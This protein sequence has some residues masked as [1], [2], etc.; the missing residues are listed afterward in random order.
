MR[1]SKNTLR[2][3][4][5]LWSGRRWCLRALQAWSFRAKGLPAS[6]AQ[7]EPSPPCSWDWPLLDPAHKSGT[8]YWFPGISTPLIQDK[9]K[10]KSKLNI[11]KKFRW[12]WQVTI[13][14]ESIPYML[15]KLERYHDRFAESRISKNR[16]NWLPHTDPHTP[17]TQTYENHCPV[18]KKRCLSV[19]YEPFRRTPFS[20]FYNSKEIFTIV[21]SPNILGRL[22]ISWNRLTRW[23]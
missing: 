1:F 6:V 20:A 22:E 4:K 13:N 7:T 12:C 5:K 3:L 2:D 19:F 23:G 8:D 11:A 9:G 21:L 14:T 16:Y 10:Q 15:T 17:F 18:S